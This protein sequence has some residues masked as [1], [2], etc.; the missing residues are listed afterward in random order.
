M[1]FRDVKSTDSELEILNALTTSSIDNQALDRRNH[2]ASPPKEIADLT[3]MGI[4]RMHVFQQVV[5]RQP[6]ITFFQIQ[7]FKII[8]RT[9]T[10]AQLHT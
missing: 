3:R 4:H 6:I 7:A 8:S 1:N 9:S 10:R 5:C 2:P